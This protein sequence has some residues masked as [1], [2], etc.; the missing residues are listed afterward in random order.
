MRIDNRRSLESLTLFTHIGG[1]ITM[2]LGFLVIGMDLLNNDFKHIQVGIFIF[3][4][5][6]SYL[7]ISSTISSILSTETKN[8]Y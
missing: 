4:I 2:F 5:G 1:L 7:K 8:D 3:A 6:Y